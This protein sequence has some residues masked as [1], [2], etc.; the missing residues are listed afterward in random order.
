MLKSRTSWNLV[1]F[2]SS[3]IKGGEKGV[4]K[5]LG[6]D[7]EEQQLFQLLGPT[8][9]P[10]NKLVSSHSE[11]LLVLGQVTSNTNSLDSPWPEFEGSHHLPPYSILYVA[12]QHPHSNGFQ[13]RDSQGGI[14][15]LSQFG[16]P[17]FWEL[18]T[19]SSDLRLG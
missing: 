19:P 9:K 11:S 16:L 5:A 10:T 4:L 18:I 12:P 1:P 17:R 7:Q 3:S 14:S 2:P 6:L 8:S 15:K 13:S